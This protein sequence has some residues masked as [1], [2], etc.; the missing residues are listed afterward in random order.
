M[1]PVSAGQAPE[2]TGSSLEL[3]ESSTHNTN[4]EAVYSTF[5]KSSKQWI[6]SAASF[7][8]MFSGLSSFIYYPAISPLAAS[9]DT[10][11]QLI[12]L[13]ITSYLIVSGLVPSIVGDL[14]DR[15]GRRPLY[16]VTFAVYFAANVGLALQ[17]S[18]SALLVL[19]MV[20]SAGSSGSSLP[21]LFRSERTADIVVKGTITLAYGV[22]ADIAPPAERGSYVG[23]LMGL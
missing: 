8:A 12:N 3:A 4:T 18:Y 9:L 10:S 13:T 16:L 21:L 6:S 5:S 17:N 23:I 15:T 2:R 20:Q 22:L 7:A 19:R 11:V 14:A 1:Q